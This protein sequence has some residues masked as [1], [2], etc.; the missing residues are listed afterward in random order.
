MNSRYGIQSVVA[1]KCALKT[2]N[3]GD[4]AGDSHVQSK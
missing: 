1:I 4:T 2:G 3:G